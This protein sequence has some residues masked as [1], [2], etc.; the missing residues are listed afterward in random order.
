MAFNIK[1]KRL[2]TKLGVV[3]LAVVFVCACFWAGGRGSVA[4]A[5]SFIKLVDRELNTGLYDYFDDS[6]VFRLPSTIK[7]S[8][9]ISL[10][11]QL[12]DHSS[13]MDVYENT[14]TSKSFSEFAKTDE[15]VEIR[16]SIKNES[17]KLINML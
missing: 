12:K 16:D 10:I 11:V 17:E 13:V 2:F 4:V 15:A 9:T 7:D 14:I 5:E 1:Q 3:S 8:D 6:V